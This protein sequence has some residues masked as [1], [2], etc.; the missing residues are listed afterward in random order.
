MTLTMGELFGGYGG[1]GLGLAAAIAEPIEPSWYADIAPAATK[2]WSHRFPG[3]PNLGDVTEVNWSSVPAVD[4]L[5]GGSP[6]Q[7]L[8]QAGRRSGMTPG[9]RSNLWVEMREAIAVLRPRLVVWENVRGAM[10]SE[11][12]SALEP[13][14]GCVGG[15]G[16]RGPVLRALGRVLGDLSDLGY[17]GGWYGLLASDVGY[18]HP[19]FRVFVAAYPRSQELPCRARPGQSQPGRI[20][21]G[22]PRDGADPGSYLPTPTRRD[23]KGRNQRDDARC[24]PGAL[25]KL[26]PTPTT[27]HSSGGGYSGQSN[28][29]LRDVARTESFGKYAAAVRAQEAITR[30]APET[31]ERGPKGGRRVRAEF[32][33]WMMGLPDGWV[34]G[35]P[36]ITYP[37]S[38]ALLG[39]GVIPGQAAH[40]LRTLLLELEE[41]AA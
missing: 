27:R 35:V 10:S 31:T 30:P 7:D 22:R 21:V 14:P 3:V 23:H 32:S 29:T 38:M 1:L 15:P 17:V 25:L 33:E 37:E 36:G 2:L 5:T 28:V 39:N 8:S 24:L 11:A 26:L 9:T 16:D 12:D 4:I 13:C 19:R 20:G 6:C 40:A 34:T 18:C 41:A